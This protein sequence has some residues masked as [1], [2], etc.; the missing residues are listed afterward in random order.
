M[1]TPAF[2]RFSIASIKSALVLGLVTGRLYQN[3]YLLIIWEL[4]YEDIKYFLPQIGFVFFLPQRYK[5]VLCRPG[6]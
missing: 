3:G 5:S 6:I 4:T 2:N 1:A